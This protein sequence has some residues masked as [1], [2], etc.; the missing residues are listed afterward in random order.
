[1]ETDFQKS[2]G[3]GILSKKHFIDS[4]ITKAFVKWLIPFI[5][6]EEKLLKI[7]LN[8][9]HKS[10]NCNY[11]NFKDVINKYHWDDDTCFHYTYNRFMD[12]RFK[13]K[14]STSREELLNIC[15]QILEWGGVVSSNYNKLQQKDSL[16]IFLNNMKE[17]FDKIEISISELVE[18]K[19]NI[20]SGFT[21]IYTAFNDNF[22][23]YDGRVG[24][25][26]CYLIRSYYT[27]KKENAEQ[28]KNNKPPL[29]LIFG[30]GL[31]KDNGTKN[32]RNPSNELMRFSNISSDRKLHFISNIKANWLLE[33]IANQINIPQIKAEEKVFALQS[34]LFMLGKDLPKN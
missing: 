28:I 14:N 27:E 4:E 6:G 9:N 12:W 34:A 21:K 25:T 15:K 26:M 8:Y 32:N 31:G 18:N 5:N 1:M 16:D 20:N 10:Y 17:L 24:A 13:F 7:G 3:N 11:E 30:Y 19:E 23:M 22:I 29:E 2:F 33:L